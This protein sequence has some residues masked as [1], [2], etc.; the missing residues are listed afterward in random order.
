V[1]VERYSSCFISRQRSES[2][3]ED[4]CAIPDLDVIDDKD[5][6]AA[7]TYPVIRYILFIRTID[8]YYTYICHS[9]SDAFYVNWRYTGRTIQRSFGS[10]IIFLIDWC[11]LKGD[12]V[13]CNIN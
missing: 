9:V 5:R 3:Q 7:V 2:F 12:F 6:S 4:S 11:W 10:F 1:R 8:E 13:H